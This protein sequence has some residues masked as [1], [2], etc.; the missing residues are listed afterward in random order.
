[1]T[2]CFQILRI[3]QFSQRMQF[4][5]TSDLFFSGP[6][7]KAFL[8]HA[9][10]TT[11]NARIITNWQNT[12]CRNISHQVKVGRSQSTHCYHHGKGS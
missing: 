2:A 5:L 8:L 7:G 6:Q 10:V 12:L 9:S 4:D 3:V 1:M 11:F